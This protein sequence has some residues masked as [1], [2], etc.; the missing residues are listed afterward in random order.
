[1]TYFGMPVIIPILATGYLLAIYL[2]LM[3]AQRMFKSSPYAPNTVTDAYVPYPSTK[4]ASQID[5][6]ESS[7]LQKI[8]QASSVH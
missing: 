7:Q 1:M 6:V 4:Q 5:E 3:L 8:K 2:L